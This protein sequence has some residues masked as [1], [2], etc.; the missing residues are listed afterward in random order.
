MGLDTIEILMKVED[1]FGIKI[2]DREAEKIL[3]VGDFHDAVWRQLSGRSSG[4]CQSQRLFYSLRRSFAGIA[5]AQIT[6]ETSPEMLFPKTN[7]R[8]RYLSFSATTG[9]KLPDLVLETFWH[10]VLTAF[11]IAAIIGGLAASLLL[12]NVFGYS[13]WVFLLPVAGM[14]LTLLLS[15]LLTPR[16]TMIAVRSMSD[17]TRHVLVLNYAALSARESTNRLEMEAIINHIIAGM[18]GIEFRKITAD[19]KIADDLGIE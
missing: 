15:R 2:S 6:P 4:V 3:T 17:F 1:T 14:L 10:Q 12:V 19:K 5:T 13:K 8:E 11:G 7:R 16:R 18:T 9:L